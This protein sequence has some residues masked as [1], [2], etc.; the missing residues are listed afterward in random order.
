LR[1]FIYCRVSTEEQSTDDHYSLEYQEEKARSRVKEKGW[2]LIKVRKDVGSGKDSNREGYQELLSDIRSRSIDVVVVYKLDRLSRNV[3]DVYHFLDLIREHNVEFVSLTE[4]F[5]TTNAMGRAMLGIA[6]VFAQLTRETI[7]ENT[8]NGLVQRAKRGKWNGS[9][10]APY[11][12]DYEKGTGLVANPAQAE[13]VRRIFHLFADRKMSASKIARLLNLEKVPTKTGAEWSV[14]LVTRLLKNPL[15]VGKVQY[16]GKVYDGEHEPIVDVDLYEA[17][18]ER[19]KVHEKIHHRTLT[20][21]FLLSGVARCA[22]C[23]L[24]LQTRYKDR[25]QKLYVC[26]GNERVASDRA[27]GG[28]AKSARILDWVVV[29]KIREVALSPEMQEMS[30]EEAKK[31]LGVELSPRQEERDRLVLELD[32]IASAF[33]KWADRLDRGLIDEEQFNLQNSRLIAK[34]KHIQERLHELDE[35]LARQDRAQADFEAV[36]AVLKDFDRLWEAATLEERQEM[37]RLL[38]ERIEVSPDEMVLKFKFRPEERIPLPRGLRG[39][40]S[41]LYGSS[42]EDLLR[43]PLCASALRSAAPCGSG[44]RPKAEGS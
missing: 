30:V 14:S 24:L 36:R 44:R 17:A 9:N 35:D 37:V 16:N 13:V 26:R 33:T 31:L 34:K 1:A 29:Q 41:P 42:E 19:L 18:Q 2:Q 5:D 8:R 28:F 7:V 43:T 32:R 6:A 22:K 39:K 12:Y 21:K 10:L 23:G 40:A 38:V 15:V 11:G 4:G 27:C 25:N 3:K 20:S